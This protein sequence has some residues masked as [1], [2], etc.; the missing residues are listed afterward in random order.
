[1]RSEAPSTLDL[2]KAWTARQRS[3]AARHGPQRRALAELHTFLKMKTASDNT[4]VRS[5]TAVALLEVYGPELEQQ[6]Y[7]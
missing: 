7:T 1:M 5:L 3:T 6:K 2:S 4:G